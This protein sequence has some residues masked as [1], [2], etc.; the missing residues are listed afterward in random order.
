M[1]TDTRD[2]PVAQ[3]LQ[4][5]AGGGDPVVS[6]WGF[7]WYDS[8]EQ[9]YARGSAAMAADGYNRKLERIEGVGVVC[10]GFPT[11]AN[12]TL[13]QYTLT[14]AN[15]GSVTYWEIQK[16]AD[17]TLRSDRLAQVNSTANLTWSAV[18][19]NTLPANPAFAVTFRRGATPADTTA[20]TY[21]GFEFGGAWQVLWTDKQ[22]VLLRKYN[23][24][25]ALFETVKEISGSAGAG[26]DEVIVHVRVQAGRLCL[27]FLREQTAGNEEDTGSW[28]VYT[29]P[30]GTDIEVASTAITFAG[31]GITAVWGLHPLSMVDGVY[32]SP[33]KPMCRAHTGAVTSSAYANIPAAYTAVSDWYTITPTVSSTN[34][35]YALTVKA[36]PETI[37][38]FGW[39]MYRSAVV[40][41]VAVEIALASSST[42]DSAVQIEASTLLSAV[43]DRP[44]ELDGATATAQVY[45]GQ[46]PTFPE[47]LRWR[48]VQMTFDNLT[49][50]TGYIRAV[51]LS[52]D[53]YG[54]T[55][56]TYTC[57][58]VSVRAKRSKF[59]ELQGSIPLGGRTINSALNW[60][61]AYIGLPASAAS[62]HAAGDVKMLPLGI[63][64]EP[65][66]WPKFG[67]T[68]WDVMQQIAALGELELGANG[69]GVY[70]TFPQSYVTSLTHNLRDVPVTVN[71]SIHAA[72]VSKDATTGTTCVIVRGTDASGNPIFSYILDDTAESNPGVTRFCPWRDV[73]D[74]QGGDRVPAEVLTALAQAAYNTRAF[75]RVEVE[76]TIQARPEIQRRD[77]VII[78]SSRMGLGT[79]D[80]IVYTL[81]HEFK[82]DPARSEMKTTLGLKR[83]V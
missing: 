83:V 70:R 28:V 17:G 35:S 34:L 5:P 66:M 81:R 40:C 48:K 23:S 30:D 38:A 74:E 80:F 79:D 58:N 52:Q 53:E 37:A 20:F 62:W 51:S 27:R 44:Y 45:T 55:V 24:S 15:T 36:V 14:P 7:H 65:Y 61:L 49:V 71:E 67:D 31:Q 4:W 64:A 69:F 43:V 78:D 56:G 68:V 73:Y 8:L 33:T 10:R 50:F 60:C 12:M 21:A 32:T 72:G 75:P 18:S 57:D 59:N 9:S 13:A 76:A 42:G 54:H 11:A 3:F 82:N 19:V 16:A 6:D 22:G 29:N 2:L 46:S 63:P 25:T 77:R 39:T 26:D 1:A 47:N 41:G